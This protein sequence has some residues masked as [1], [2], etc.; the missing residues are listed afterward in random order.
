MPSRSAWI[1]GIS[2]DY[3]AVWLAKQMFMGLTDNAVDGSVVPQLATKWSVSEDGLTWTFEMR[4]DVPWVSVNPATGEFKNLGPVTAKDVEY[5]VKRI[6]D[7]R[8]GSTSS[9]GLYII[10]GAQEYNKADPKAANFAELRDAIGVKVVDDYTVQF[11]LTQP[12]AYFPSIAGGMTVRPVQQAAVEAHPDRW[13]EPGWIVTNGPYALLDWL[14]GNRI[15]MVKNPLWYGAACRHA[16]RGHR[17]ADRQRR[18]DRHGH[19]RERRDRLHGRPRLGPAAA[20]HGPHQV[21]PRAQPGVSAEHPRLCTYYYGFMVKNKAP[22]D[23]VRVRQAFSYAIDRQ[24]L[25]DQLLK[26]GQILGQRLHR[27]GH[28]RH[29]RGRQERRRLSGHGQLRRSGEA[30]PGMVGRGGFP[31]RERIGARSDFSIPP[32]SNMR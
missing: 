13:A 2:G 25:I 15:T 27:P 16:D 4:K 14:H 32:A 11:T 7:P 3:I 19:V 22:F 17:A 20:G 10:K 26:G 12:A 30:G 18:V 21:R 28:L 8:S 5:Q 24:A 31:G 1:P 9:S 23:D 29:R 6:L